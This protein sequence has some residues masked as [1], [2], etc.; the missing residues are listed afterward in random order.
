MAGAV[1]TA[2]VTGTLGAGLCALVGLSEGAAQENI[3]AGVG[4][5]ESADWH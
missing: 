4:E 5:F 1:T 2:D 3:S